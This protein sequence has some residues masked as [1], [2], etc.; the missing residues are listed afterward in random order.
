MQHTGAGG[1]GSGQSLSSPGSCLETFRPNPFIECHGRG[2][3]HY[4]ANKY[5]FWMATVKPDDMFK[6][7]TPEVLAKDKGHD[8]R[9]RVSRCRVC[10]RP[11]KTNRAIPHPA[12]WHDVT[13][14]KT[15]TAHGTGN[16]QPLL[17]QAGFQ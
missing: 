5:S 6:S 8:L 2:S 9:S 7:Q 11:P 12:L 10:V 1:S 3:C 17:K 4:F 13:D 14:P 15:Q 16:A